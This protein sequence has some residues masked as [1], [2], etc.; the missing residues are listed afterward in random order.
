MPRKKI[1]AK[2]KKRQT[3]EW[4]LKFLTTGEGPKN[5]EPGVVDC[6]RLKGDLT[7]IRAPW[8][9]ERVEILKHHIQNKPGSRPW[10][11][12]IFDSPR[13]KK[14]FDAWFDGTF[15]EP[16]KRLGGVGS[17]SFEFL[18]VK[19]CF[20][21]GV[22][23]SFVDPFLAKYYNGTAKDANG[24]LIDS[25]YKNGDFS[26]VPID[27]DNPPCYESSAAYLQRHGLLSHEEESRLT[28]ADFE[29]VLIED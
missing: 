11:W 29:P 7:R 16:R 27:P 17:P 1:R 13:W 19:P 22:P 20:D 8:L 3:P 10:P 25:G 18:A 26:G 6:F 28:S 9:K 15:P 23:T 21:R 12:W 14:K 24:E 2:K 4:L 5:N